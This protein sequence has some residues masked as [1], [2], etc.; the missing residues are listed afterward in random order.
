MRPVLLTIAAIYFL[1]A[2]PV[3]SSAQDIQTIIDQFY[4]P[5][6]APASAE[7]RHS[8]YYVLQTMAMGEP[9]VV[10][11]GY[12][13]TSSAMVRL[14]SRVGPST[15][16]VSYDT[17]SSIAMIGI[18]CEMS[19]SDIDGNGQPDVFLRLP[20]GKGTSDWIFKW[21]GGTLVNVTPTSPY[22]QR[23]RT[24]LLDSDRFDLYHDGSLQVVSSGQIDDS[25]STGVVL[26]TPY[27]VFRLGATTYQFDKWI[28]SGAHFVSSSNPLAN[29][30][31]FVPVV[32]SIG[33]FT[34]RI[35][36]GDRTGQKRITG[37]S[38]SLDGV[39]IVADGQLT[40]QVEYLTRTVSALTS[41]NRL[42]GTLAGPADAEVT[43]TVEDSTPR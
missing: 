2:G 11:A 13:D 42:T 20:F 26:R 39:T 24:Q 5:G 12:T 31:L 28:V 18:R 37:G 41:Q 36:N 16:V 21:S 32:N 27:K 38:L 15:Y 8:C 9:D 33:P 7:D 25:S 22:N 6:L 3:A 19:A 17:P 40:S 43:I 23:E 29:V 35:T 4:P 34:I 10:A 1:L 30:S 14:L